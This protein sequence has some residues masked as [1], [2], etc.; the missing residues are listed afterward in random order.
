MRHFAFVDEISRRQPHQDVT[1]SKTRF[2]WACN[3]VIAKTAPAT[4]DL[5]ARST[6]DGARPV[7]CRVMRRL[8]LAGAGAAAASTG[9]LPPAS[10]ETRIVAPNPVQFNH[11][12]CKCGWTKN[13]K[14]PCAHPKLDDGSACYTACCSRSTQPATTSVD[15]IKVTKAESKPDEQLAEIEPS[16]SAADSSGQEEEVQEEEEEEEEEEKK[17]KELGFMNLVKWFIKNY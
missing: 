5:C 9:W 11:S 6:D 16:S 14:Q 8:V 10:A 15:E 13:R 4:F 12:E 3:T 17:T 2:A 7:R 1:G